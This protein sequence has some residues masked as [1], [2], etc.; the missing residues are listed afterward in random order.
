MPETD[1]QY[2]TRGEC[3]LMSQHMTDAI[4]S[5]TESI[6]K[7]DK[8]LQGNGKDGLVMTVNKLMWKNQILDKGVSIL[9][10]ILTSIVTALM[11]RYI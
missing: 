8:T 5:N 3:H 7:L 4:R 1:N 11:L 6:D 2:M 9:I 10:A